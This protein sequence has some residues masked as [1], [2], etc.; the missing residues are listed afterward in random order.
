MTTGSGP[1]EATVQEA[2]RDVFAHADVDGYL[3]ARDLGTGQS[4]AH[5]GDEH[6]VLASVFKIAILVEMYR[7][8]DSGELDVTEPVTVPLE[9]RSEGGT[10]LSVMCDPVTMSWRDLG[11]LMMS[12]SDN[13]ATD[14]ICDRVGVDRVN[15]SLQ[16]FGL[17]RT[18]VLGSCRELFDSVREDLGLAPDSPIDSVDLTD[19][20]VL[21][22]LRAVDPMQATRSTAREAADLLAGIWAD[23]VASPQ[24][25]AEMRRV[26]GQQV[27]P[28]RLAA[29][30]PE[31][32]V[33]TSGK[34]GTLPPWRNEA[35]VVEYPDGTT[36]AV[37]V[38]TRGRRPVLT[39]PAADAA[40]GTSS[41]LA[42]DF[43][44]RDR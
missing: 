39:D 23:E 34:T 41:R 22:K 35:G 32:D 11:S 40:I 8:Q 36:Y 5:A 21:R 25:C 14:V 12:I 9:G 28:H 1:A 4:V 18:E 29:G 44:R 24:A 30:F 33:T 7:Q 10:G 19:P 13:A 3:V 17:R 27:W 16:S 26:L 6:V 2:L 43:L 20:A 38:F 42:V 37:A 15:R 31:D